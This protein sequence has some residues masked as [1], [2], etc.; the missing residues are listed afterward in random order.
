MTFQSARPDA[1]PRAD[2]ETAASTEGQQMRAATGSDGRR[3]R[4]HG[5]FL[6]YLR[7]ELQRRKRQALLTAAWPWGSG[8]S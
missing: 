1:Q 4:A 5:F 8:W 6:T 3:D 2:D 7:R